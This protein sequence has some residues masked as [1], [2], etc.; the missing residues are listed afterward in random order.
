MLYMVFD[1]ESIGIHGETF[2]VGWVVVDEQGKE[3]DAARFACDPSTAR[4]DDDG[5]A[6]V[7]EHCPPL[8]QTHRALADMRT[9]FWLVWLY[10]KERGAV[11]AAD[12]AW[13][14]EARFLIACVD[15]NPQARMWTGPYPLHDVATA[16]LVAGF[17]P[18]E[19]VERLPNEEPKHDPLADARQSA[20]LWLE[21]LH[22]R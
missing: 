22:T 18:L 16:R 13:P 21:A 7:S 20:R 6:W 1:C 11:L 8:K 2:S 15:D 3:H 9:D 12:C 5:R 10:W 17:D 4:G 14:V 19:I